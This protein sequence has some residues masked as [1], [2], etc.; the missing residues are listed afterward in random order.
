[1]NDYQPYNDFETSEE[2]SSKTKVALVLAIIGIA[3]AVIGMF[4]NCC[5]AIFGYVLCIPALIVSIVA[6]VMKNKIGFIGIG[7]SV[8]GLLV[9]IFNSILGALMFTL[10]LL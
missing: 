4:S 6:V 10:P 2:S 3:L 9:T 8:L 7:V 1:M 5:L